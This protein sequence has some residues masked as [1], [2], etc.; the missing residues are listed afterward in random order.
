MSNVGEFGIN[1][2]D[3][4]AIYDK[5]VEYRI[6]N[7]TLNVANYEP[8]YIA[9]WSEPVEMAPEP[10]RFGPIL[11]IGPGPTHSLLV[12]P[13]LS[14]PDGAQLPGSDDVPAGL[15][16]THAPE[17]GYVILMLLIFTFVAIRQRYRRVRGSAAG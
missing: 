9:R 15:P 13:D 5:Y 12:P 1:V 16:E 3:Q 2:Y 4:I 10:V 8:I 7:P 11:W 17:P 6:T 14:R